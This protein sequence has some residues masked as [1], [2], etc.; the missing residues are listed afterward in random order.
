MAIVL[1]MAPVLVLM[2]LAGCTL[3]E[4]GAV[5]EVRWGE[6]YS[7]VPQPGGFS[8]HDTP[9]F[10]REDSS[11]GKRLVGT[12]SYRAE[13]V[14]KPKPLAE[15]YRTELAK[16]GWIFVNETLDEEKSA[17]KARFTKGEDKLDLVLWVE[18]RKSPAFSVLTVKMNDPYGN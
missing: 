2:L 16:E 5:P 8:R 12:Y 3:T 15:F 17:W 11:S 6:A 9:P 10:S 7:D 18:L 1:R 14:V 4:S 13:G